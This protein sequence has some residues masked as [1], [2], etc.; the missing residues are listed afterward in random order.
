VMTRLYRHSDDFRM[1]SQNEGILASLSDEFSHAVRMS[2][3][4]RC[5]CFLGLTIEHLEYHRICVTRNEEKIM[6][7]EKDFGFLRHSFNYEGRD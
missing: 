7:L 4:T 2:K 3:W 6:E 1:S 5:D